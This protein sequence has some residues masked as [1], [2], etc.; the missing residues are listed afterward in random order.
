[1]SE[2]QGVVVVMV[3]VVDIVKYFVKGTKLAKRHILYLVFGVFWGYWG[4]CLGRGCP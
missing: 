3:M 1:M 4:T 2:P